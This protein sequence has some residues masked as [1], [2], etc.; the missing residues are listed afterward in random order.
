MLTQFVGSQ[1]QKRTSRIWFAG[2]EGA[3]K[4]S[5][6]YKLK[7]GECIQPQTSAMSV[8][9]EPF[10]YRKRT[11]I[12]WEIGNISYSHH[13]GQDTYTKEMK[14]IIFR[15][16]YQQTKVIIFFIDSSDEMSILN[17]KHELQNIAKIKCL[18]KIPIIVFCN[19]QDI[20]PDDDQ[21]DN[22]VDNKSDSKVFS[23]KEIAEMIDLRNLLRSDNAHHGH[24]DVL[25]PV[26]SEH[27]SE[28]SEVSQVTKPVD[29]KR[30]RMD[31]DTESV[32]SHENQHYLA[33]MG[34]SVQTGDGLFELLDKAHHI[35]SQSPEDTELAAY[36]GDI[37]ILHYRHSSGDLHDEMPGNQGID[38]NVG[39]WLE[40]QQDQDDDCF[41]QQ[42]KDGTLPDI[43]GD[44]TTGGF[45]HY[46]LVR[47]IWIHHKA[48]KSLQDL[49]DLIESF[50]KD[51]YNVTTIYFWSQI[52]LYALESID[53][54]ELRERVRADFRIF[55]ACNPEICDPKHLLRKYY[56]K[57]MLFKTLDDPQSFV[58]PDIKPLPSLITDI[59][60]LKELNQKTSG[61]RK[62]R[63]R[64][65]QLRASQ[66]VQQI[67]NAQNAEDAQN[68]QKA[69][70]APNPQNAPSQVSEVRKGKAVSG[71]PQTADDEDGRS[72]K[73]KERRDTIPSIAKVSK[74]LRKSRNLS[75]VA[76]TTDFPGTELDGDF[77]LKVADGVV[78]LRDLRHVDLLR[79]I[80]CYFN[81][82]PK[83]HR[84]AIE[85]LDEDFKEI[86]GDEY[87]ETLTM[88]WVHMIQ[89]FV[90]LLQNEK[91]N[92][93]MEFW[94]ILSS[95]NWRYAGCASYNLNDVNLWKTFYSESAM[96][97]RGFCKLDASAHLVPPDV[98]HLP[99]A[100]CYYVNSNKQKS[101]SP[102]L[103]SDREEVQLQE[104]NRSNQEEEEQK[105]DDQ[106]DV[107]QDDDAQQD[108][109]DRNQYGYIEEEEANGVMTSIS[110]PRSERIQDTE[111]VEPTDDTSG[112]KQQSEQNPS[113]TATPPPRDPL[114]SHGIVADKTSDPPK[115]QEDDNNDDGEQRG[116][117][118]DEHHD[119]QTQSVDQLQF[120][121][122]EDFNA[123][124]RA[125]DDDDAVSSN[126]ERA[127][128]PPA[129][130][131][132]Q[133]PG[134][135]RTEQDNDG[136]EL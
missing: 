68:A 85:M 40:R 126:Q 26:Q 122:M 31:S 45:D 50:Q 113:L 106:D 33:M 36:N 101:Q 39:N 42:I 18:D 11:V 67:E 41:I 121:R 89:Y 100:V 77:L 115:D 46:N 72:R 29:A 21:S 130:A 95:N 74:D 117:D 1:R 127:D 38:E 56:T 27:D 69:Q 19:K 10:K 60:S 9:Q 75:E 131:V 13:Q 28:V 24:V 5:A 61:R 136:E 110:S 112:S 22:K 53:D 134:N 80:W 88:F 7:L 102:H 32:L 8:I 16:Y 128:E 118:Q 6:I 51:E 86:Q 78:K 132:L 98:G 14:H 64:I 49:C 82:N 54:E 123:K 4:T 97:H 73:K 92:T 87:H 109:V 90:T 83:N 116:D 94:T 62:P 105:Y 125:P 66:E 30:H 2:L 47:L 3:G 107:Q 55:V 23:V 120:N 135:E 44:T 25:K 81:A 43:N 111:V 37:D 129:K 12:F 124:D 114:S 119:V 70:N 20:E 71:P 104:A 52:I 91:A 93:F 17:S 133:V 48:Q 65:L 84:N 57:E 63:I 79:F 35:L 15:H 96:H 34:G 108:D 103:Q 59:Q 76:D 99:S 58:M